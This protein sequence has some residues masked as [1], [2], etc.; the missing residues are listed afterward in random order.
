MGHAIAILGG[1]PKYDLSLDRTVG[2]DDRLEIIDDK[3]PRDAVA[4]RGR[5]LQRPDEISV[6]RCHATSLCTSRERL[7]TM[8]N[9]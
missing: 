3:H 8:P 5:I 2:L 9:P 4:S 6:R 1:L 7:R